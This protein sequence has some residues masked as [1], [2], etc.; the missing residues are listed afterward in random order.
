MIIDCCFVLCEN[1][2]KVTISFQK[3]AFMSRYLPAGTN[4]TVTMDLAGMVS[5]RVSFPLL[6]PE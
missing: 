3:R 2:S 4:S 6:N 5:V 1:L